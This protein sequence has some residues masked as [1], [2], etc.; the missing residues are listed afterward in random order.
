M[1]GLR[2]LNARP[3]P[4]RERIYFSLVPPTLCE[5]Y[6][7]DPVTLTNP[8]GISL[9]RIQA[10]PGEASVRLT[11]RH[12]ADA[13]DPALFLRLD[14]S[15]YGSLQITWII[16]TDPEGPRFGVDLDDDGNVTEL[17][18]RYRNLREEEVAMRAG[19]APGQIRPGLRML[20]AILDR[21]EAF[22]LRLGKPALTLEAFFYHNAL[23]YERHG[24]GYLAGQERLEAIHQGFSPGGELG[25]L[26]GGQTPFRTPGQGTTIRGRS[27][28]IHD[29][30][31]PRRWWPP[32]MYRPIGVRFQVCTAPGVPY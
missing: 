6:S 17:G 16:L 10:S 29:G 32:A 11:L 14:E 3:T 5:K 1:I 20:R 21:I 12:R 13:V 7:L 4:E 24:F 27:W 9:A 22:A 25:A 15:R 28:A 26:L 8:E 23:I 18:A 19:L 30:I 31:L 2:E